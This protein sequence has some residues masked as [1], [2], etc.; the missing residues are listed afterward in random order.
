MDYRLLA[1]ALV[2]GIDLI[3][4]IAHSGDDDAIDKIRDLTSKL[5]TSRPPGLEPQ[6]ILAEITK[7]ATRVQAD[8]AEINRKIAEKFPKDK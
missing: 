8:D 5:S 7:H 4:E 1:Q 2:L 6:K 3:K